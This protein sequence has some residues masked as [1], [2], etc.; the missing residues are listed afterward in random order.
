MLKIIDTIQ[1]SMF[2]GPIWLFDEKENVHFD[3]L[4]NKIQQVS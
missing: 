1:G 2:A 4:H 3:L